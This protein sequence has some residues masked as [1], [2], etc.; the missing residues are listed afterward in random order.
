M[1]KN[2]ANEVI[3]ELL[4]FFKLR[5]NLIETKPQFDGNIEKN[6]AYH[7]LVHH[8]L[9]TCVRFGNVSLKQHAHSLPLIFDS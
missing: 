7:A 1:T 2:D 5:F 6:L 8:L 4:L 3:T 9:Y